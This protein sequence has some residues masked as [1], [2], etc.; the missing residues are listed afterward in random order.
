MTEAVKTLTSPRNTS[1]EHKELF[2]G[3]I[4]RDSENFQKI[5][6]WFDSHSPF[7][8]RDHLEALDLGLV[9]E[10]NQ[11]TC[12]CSESIGAS[13]QTLMNGMAYTEVSIKRSNQLK[14]LQGIYS[15]IKVN[16]ENIS[17]GLLTLFLRLSVII[18][19]KSEKEIEDYF[20][21]EVTSSL[22]SLFKDGIGNEVKKITQQSQFY[23][24]RMLLIYLELP[25]VA[26][27]YTAAIGT[28][29]KYLITFLTSNSI[30]K[31]F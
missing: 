15:N 20:Y 9:D 28:K 17:V 1:R 21:Y 18:E 24:C 25:M 8:V 14:N 3:R 23:L 16:N 22:M 31:L 26:L 6:S 2:A 30:S 5:K 4:K 27:F 7:D 12:D 10:L 29:V 13:I 11:V 19:K